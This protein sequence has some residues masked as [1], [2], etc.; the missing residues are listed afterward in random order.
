MKYIAYMYEILEEKLQNTM[1]QK[2]MLEG[3]VLVCNVLFLPCQV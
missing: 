3:F 1:F 2:R